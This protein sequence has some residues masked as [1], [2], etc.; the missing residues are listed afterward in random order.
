MK[1]IKSIFGKGVF[2]RGSNID[3]DQIIPARFLKCT[4][5]T[6]LSSGLFYD[7][8]FTEDG[9]PLE[10]PLNGFEVGNI[11]F[12]EDNFGCGSSR[13]HAPQALQK[14]GFEAIVGL[15]FGSIFKAN[16]YQ[17]G[18][19]CFIIDPDNLQLITGELFKS[20][21]NDVRIDVE[22]LNLSCGGKQFRISASQGEQ[23]SLLEGSYDPL[24]QLLANR[25]RIMEINMKTER[26]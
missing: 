11:L 24:A 22:K 4:T 14:S 19:P 9:T 10:H 17:I 13:E 21:S 16:C 5:F 7:Q 3:T 26:V 1:T 12:T 25:E 18:L 6:E 23:Q 15:S 2:I 8:R 20:Q